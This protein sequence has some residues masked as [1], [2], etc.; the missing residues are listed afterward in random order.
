M[1]KIN[2]EDMFC[3]KEFGYFPYSQGTTTAWSMMPVQLSRN[4]ELEVGQPETVG[5]SRGRGEYQ[6]GTFR[7]H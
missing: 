1:E 4:L 6:D 2:N 7:G 3:L 5:R